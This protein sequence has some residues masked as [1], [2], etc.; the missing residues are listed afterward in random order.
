MTPDSQS[1]TTDRESTEPEGTD[2][3]RKRT[4]RGRASAPPDSLPT[5][6]PAKPMLNSP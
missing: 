4:E 5:G 6:S 3:N 2:S 1:K